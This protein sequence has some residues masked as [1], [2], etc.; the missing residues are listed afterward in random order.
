MLLVNPIRIICFSL[1]TI[2][3]EEIIILGVDA[4]DENEDVML[5]L[6]QY[7]RREFHS[8]GADII[9]HYHLTT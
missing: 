9:L 7:P 3:N 8:L 4:K 6:E 2:V 1:I 5:L